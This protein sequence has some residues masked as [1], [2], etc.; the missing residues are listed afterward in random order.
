MTDPIRERKIRAEIL[1]KQVKA[2]NPCYLRRL[3]VLPGRRRAPDEELIGMAAAIRRRDCL[4]VIA[5]ELG[6]PNWQQAK[7]A[8][9][10]DCEALEFGT[11]LYPACGAGLNRWYARYEEA[12]PVREASAGY[13]LAYKRHYLVVDRYFIESLGLDPDDADWT[14]LGFDWVHP[15]SLAARTRLYNKLVARLPRGG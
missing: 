9:T 1:H 4:T 11:L 8:L 7:A 12:A 5:A 6:F 3:R 13:L 2:R 10:G 15:A 14:E